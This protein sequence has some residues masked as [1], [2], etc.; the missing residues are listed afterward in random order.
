MDKKSTVSNVNAQTVTKEEEIMIRKAETLKD[1]G[2]LKLSSCTQK[3]IEQRFGSDV[4]S[5]VKVGR[6]VALSNDTHPGRT[7]RTPEYLRELV[8]AL[9]EAGFIRHDLYPR[10]WRVWTLYII[11]LCP[12]S[13][14]RTTREDLANFIDCKTFAFSKEYETMPAVN[15][16]EFKQV[17]TVLDS[18]EERERTVLVLY[19]GLDCG[20]PRTLEE[21]GREFSLS[22]ERI[23]QIE[24]KALRKMRNPFRIRELPE[25]FGFVHPVKPKVDIVTDVNTDIVHPVEPKVDIAIDVN[26][27]ICNL[28]LSIR[29]YNCLKRA[30]IETVEDILNY[31]DLKKVKNLGR[32]SAV[33]SV[34]GV[35]LFG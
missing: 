10:T 7:N 35:P 12:F 18:L 8:G 15:D 34:Y 31:S 20:M 16:E 21:I 4:E 26:T 1:I 19:Y 22:R 33:V 2:E 5:V 24:C 25:L 27:D 14:Y 29:A 30:G 28:G 23:R 11:I 9:D 17:M 3:L 13:S 32:R 6:D